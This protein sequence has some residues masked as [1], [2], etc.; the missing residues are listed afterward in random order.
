MQRINRT[1]VVCLFITL[2]VA[3]LLAGCDGGSGNGDGT[4]TPLADETGTETPSALTLSGTWEG[5][6]QSRRTPESGTL[7]VTLT[8]TGTTLTGEVEVTGSPCVSAETIAGERSGDTVVFGTAS[9]GPHH[10]MFSGTVAPDGTAMDGTY[11][12]T[13]GPC[14]GDQG[15]WSLT[16]V[17]APVRR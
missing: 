16:R 10:S 13:G 8:Q 15:T 11:A 9:G 12:V 1:P 17:T 6:W 2:V 14:A 5:V 4:E 3:V 7:L